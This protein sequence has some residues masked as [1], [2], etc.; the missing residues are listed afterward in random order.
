MLELF[1]GESGSCNSRDP[2]IRTVPLMMSKEVQMD[3]EQDGPV[4]SGSFERDLGMKWHGSMFDVQVNDYDDQVSPSVI[5]Q[6]PDLPA[7]K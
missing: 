6:L 5:K 7:R 3:R 4:E 1:C 2:V